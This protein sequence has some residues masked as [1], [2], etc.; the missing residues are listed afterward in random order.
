VR[1]ETAQASPESQLMAIWVNDGA[2]PNVIWTGSIALARLQSNISNLRI[3]RRTSSI[4]LNNVH[5]SSLCSGYLMR[6]A[7]SLL[8]HSRPCH[9]QLLCRPYFV[10]S[11]CIVC[12]PMSVSIC[13]CIQ[14]ILQPN[15]LCNASHPALCMLNPASRMNANAIR[16]FVS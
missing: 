5:S 7:S 11:V 4:W 10:F 9:I 3:S 6:C 1:A 12:K 14:W 8:Q 15:S 2:R 16:D 13:V